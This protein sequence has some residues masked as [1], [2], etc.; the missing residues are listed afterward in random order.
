MFFNLAEKFVLSVTSVFFTSTDC[1]NYSFYLLLGQLNHCSPI[2]NVYF[3][4]YLNPIGKNPLK[5][6]LQGSVS[7]IKAGMMDAKVKRPYQSSF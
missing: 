2:Y 6:N 1:K 7:V 4:T 3:N 5:L